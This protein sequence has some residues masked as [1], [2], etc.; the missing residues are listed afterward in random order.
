MAAL[1]KKDMKAAEALI[2]KHVPP[3]DPEAKDERGRS[4]PKPKYSLPHLRARCQY[5]VALKDWNRALVDAEAV[6]ASQLASAGGMSLRTPELDESEAL[7]DEIKEMKKQA[8][9]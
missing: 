9:K 1:N 2:M 4:L 5:Y 3:Y 7:R 6:V 8:E